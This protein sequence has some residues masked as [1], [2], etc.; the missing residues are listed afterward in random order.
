MD[1]T[2]SSFKDAIEIT[3][4][5]LEYEPN[6]V[7]IIRKLIMKA[8]TKDYN[9]FTNTNG[10]RKYVKEK[11]SEGIKEEMLKVI[12][13][14]ITSIDDL[15]TKYIDKIFL[16]KMDI[17]QV[18][19]E[20]RNRS[21]LEEVSKRIRIISTTSSD[22]N[23]FYN[24][25]WNYYI[26][27]FVDTN[28]PDAYYK[29]RYDMIQAALNFALVNRDNA[30]ILKRID[31]NDKELNEIDAIR[32][33]EEYVYNNEVKQL[34]Y[35]INN[36]TVLSGLLLQNL[37][38][39]TYYK[40]DELIPKK[41]LKDLDSELNKFEMQ[42]EKEQ[43]LTQVIINNSIP[44]GFNLSREEVMINLLKNTI[45]LNVYTNNKKIMDYNE[46]RLYSGN[47]TLNED[48]IHDN[49]INNN[50]IANSLLFNGINTNINDIVNI[51]NHLNVNQLNFLIKIY[52]TSRSSKEN[53]KRLDESSYF[54]SNEQ[55]HILNILDDNKL[56]EKLQQNKLTK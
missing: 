13:S 35:I 37:F 29:I 5:K 27:L 42:Q 14:T 9:Y 18:L 17:N 1:Y 25:L 2:A 8:L 56:I 53:I 23:D 47:E 20:I 41:E 7:E 30:G 15:V 50:I 31:P 38:N 34:L 36:N 45:Y 26:N 28:N 33:V 43:V 54:G 21:D 32:I 4:D 12:N 44:N 39:Y 24:N 46:R 3:L 48:E 52:V 51:I 55:L 22:D 16:N 10:A 40:K 19:D 49:I 6:N 11:T